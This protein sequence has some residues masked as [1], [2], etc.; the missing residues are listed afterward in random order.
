MKIAVLNSDKKTLAPTTPRRARLLLAEKK[1]SVF[2]RFPFTIILHRK[3]DVKS[4]QLPLLNLKLDPGS[5]KTG[6]AVVDQTNGVVIFGAELEHRSQQITASLIRRRSLRRNRRNRRTRYRQARFGNRAKGKGWIAPSHK[7]RIAQTLTWVKRIMKFYPISNLAVENVRFD[8]QKLQNPE[9]HGVEY[10]QGE[11]FGYEVKEYLLIK[12][13]HLCV[14]S[15]KGKCSE[16]LEIEHLV[17]KTRGGSNRVSNL[18]IACTN[19]N[20]EKGALTAEEFGFPSLQGHVKHSL[21]DAVSVNITRL[22]LIEDLKRFNLPIEF[23]SGGLTKFN[24][25][26]RGLPKT[27]WIDAACVG[28]STPSNLVVENIKPLII[29]SMGHGTRQMC[30][31]DK[32]GFPI[33][34]RTNSKTFLGF[35]TGDIV[36]AKIPKG[37]FK[38]N[39]FGRITIRQRPGFTLNGF[40]VNPK[41]LTILHRADGYNYS[42]KK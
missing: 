35:Q 42:Y 19:H 22:A 34:H 10:Q 27:H 33:A 32:F 20:R 4:V 39:A 31:T 2:R 16:K 41:Y 26:K 11:L 6:I 38:G 29:K 24:R 18:A 36:K 7:S 14:Y 25:I 28:H 17:P 12:F 1:A 8:L 37:K 40:N 13:N 30:R 3:V 5:R 9:I 15:S 23:G 21:K